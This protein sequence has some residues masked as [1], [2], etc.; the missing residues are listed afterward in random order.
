MG[1]ERGDFVGLTFGEFGSRRFRKVC[2]ELKIESQSAGG[3][4]EQRSDEG[5]ML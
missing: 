3:R 2:T 1:G 5:L 4:E